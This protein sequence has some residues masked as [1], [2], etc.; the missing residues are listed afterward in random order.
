VYLSVVLCVVLFCVVL[1]VLF[2]KGTDKS[3]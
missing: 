2:V 1:F 3:Y